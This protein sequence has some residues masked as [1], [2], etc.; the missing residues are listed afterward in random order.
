MLK[1]AILHEQGVHF[2]PRVCSPGI[3]VSKDGRTA[4]SLATGRCEYVLG[5]MGL[6]YGKACFTF[7][8]AKDKRADE[9]TCLGVGIPPIV[10]GSYDRSETVIDFQK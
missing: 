2:D 9:R 1:D 8:V 5:C 7:M 3:I 4:T 10:N 6:S